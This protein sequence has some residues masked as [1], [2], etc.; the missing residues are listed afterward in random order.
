MCPGRGRRRP[1]GRAGLLQVVETER[2]T[3]P[4]TVPKRTSDEGSDALT[5]GEP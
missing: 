5:D 2:P 1:P 4:P 3:G